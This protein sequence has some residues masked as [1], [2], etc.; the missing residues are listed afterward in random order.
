MR[1]DTVYGAFAYQKSGLTFRRLL[2]YS[3]LGPSASHLEDHHRK[4]SAEHSVRLE[5]LERGHRSWNHQE[6]WEPL[7]LSNPEGFNEGLRRLAA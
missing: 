2:N 7:H 4:V 1:I 3:W 6:G 5:G